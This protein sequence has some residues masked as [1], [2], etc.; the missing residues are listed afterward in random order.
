MMRQGRIKTH[1]SHGVQRPNHGLKTVQSFANKRRLLALA[2]LFQICCGMLI[3]IG[4]SWS[5]RESIIITKLLHGETWSRS[6]ALSNLLLY[7]SECR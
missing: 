6:H 1:S 7:G 4:H 5:C 2:K 3:I